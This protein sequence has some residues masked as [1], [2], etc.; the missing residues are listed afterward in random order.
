LKK[1]K[2]WFDER[3]SELVDEW[4]QEKLQW[5]HDQRVINIDNLNNVRREANKHFRNNKREYLKDKINELST[6]RKIREHERLI[7]GKN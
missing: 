3:C 6:N 5:L 7:Y 1:H 2:P 4:K